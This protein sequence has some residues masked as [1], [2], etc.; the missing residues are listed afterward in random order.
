MIKT[1]AR[2]CSSEKLLWKILK[3]SRKTP[4]PPSLFDKITLLKE[5]SS[6]DAYLYFLQTFQNSIHIKTEAVP[7]LISFS[8][9]YDLIFVVN[10]EI[11][12]QNTKGVRVWSR[13]I[14]R[15]IYRFWEHLIWMPK[16][17]KGRKRKTNISIKNEK[18]AISNSF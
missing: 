7:S 1:L 17:K 8:L 16:F 13:G 12:W 5:S 10:T 18:T 2:I 15:S 9:L 6:T 4:V 14:L 11:Y 3:I